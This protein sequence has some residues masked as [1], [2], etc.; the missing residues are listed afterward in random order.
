V[1]LGAQSLRDLREALGITTG[2]GKCAGHAKAVL[3]EA[4]KDAPGALL[5][6][7]A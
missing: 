2:C 3:R 6:S 1:D 5:A 4:L 7:A